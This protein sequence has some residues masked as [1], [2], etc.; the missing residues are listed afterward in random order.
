VKD[1][2]DQ[3]DVVLHFVEDQIV[4]DD[5]HPISKCC[6]LGIVGNTPDEGVGL[7]RLQTVFDMIEHGRRSPWILCGEIRHQIHEILLGNRKQTDG[8]L[9]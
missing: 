7:E 2:M 4:L 3:D 5:E 1:A 8:V 6:E 9:T